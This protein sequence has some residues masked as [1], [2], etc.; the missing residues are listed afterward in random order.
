MPFT[1]AEGTKAG[2]LVVY[3]VS[4][5]VKNICLTWPL[6]KLI[7]AAV[8][9]RAPR[10]GAG[11]LPERRASRAAEKRAHTSGGADLPFGGRV[12]VAMK[13]SDSIGAGG[14]ACSA[15]DEG[16]SQLTLIL[17]AV[18]EGDEQAADQIPDLV[19]SELRRLAA[20]KL[21]AERPGSTVVPTA[22]AHE[23]LLRLDCGHEAHFFAAAAEAMRRILIENA[24]PKTR[25]FPPPLQPIKK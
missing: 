6:E 25:L 9:N 22:L 23:A 15:T 20:Q 4:N 16:R 11:A 19:C 13:W 3:Y 21:A 7:R 24:L 1:D 2:A 17:D 8:S 12:T 10:H 14:H 18:G 5:L